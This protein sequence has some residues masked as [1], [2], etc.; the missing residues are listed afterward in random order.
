[1]KQACFPLLLLALFSLGSTSCVSKKRFLEETAVRDS[2]N[3][4]L[5]NRIIACNQ[6]IGNLQLKLAEKTGEANALRELFREKEKTI[7]RLEEE[8][9]SLSTR[10]LTQQQRMDL[11]LKK[12]DEQI[13]ALENQ[14]RSFAAFLSDQEARINALKKTI[15][16]AMPSY[17]QQGMVLIPEGNK[18]RIRLPETM[19]FNPGSTSF[20]KSATDVL[21]KLATI[22][23]QNPDLRITVES[24]TDTQPPKSRNF[25]DNYDLTCLRSAA[26]VRTLTREFDLNPSQVL[27]VGKGEF[28]PAASNETPEGRQ[29]NRRTEIVVETRLDPLFDMIREAAE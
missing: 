27:P 18:L 12:K 3:Y 11:T 10:S 2:L 16:V 25:T 24:H 15:E 28:E 7:E 6:E 29:Q 8:I 20:S 19:L 23:R 17:L 14:I 9:E 5:N 4:L 22:L 26:V 21:E 13:E 1:M